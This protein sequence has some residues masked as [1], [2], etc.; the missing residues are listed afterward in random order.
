M[1][2]R[3]DSVTSC[4][5]ALGGDPDLRR[6]VRHRQL[7]SF[8]AAAA[9]AGPG[10]PPSQPPALGIGGLGRYRIH[11]LPGWGRDLRPRRGHS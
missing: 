3:E 1:G 6:A 5:A 8:L 2:R 11:E 9:A 7:L 4:V 10:R